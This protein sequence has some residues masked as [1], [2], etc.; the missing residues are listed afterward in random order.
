MYDVRAVRWRSRA[1]GILVEPLQLGCLCCEGEIR[2]KNVENAKAG[3]VLVYF[4]G[5]PVDFSFSVTMVLLIKC[6]GV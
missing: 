6:L 3:H 1:G 2:M 5:M 4:K